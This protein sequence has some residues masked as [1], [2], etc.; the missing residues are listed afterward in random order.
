MGTALIIMVALAGWAL[1]ATGLLLA[2]IGG[3][4]KDVADMRLLADSLCRALADQALEADRHKQQM[5]EMQGQK[6]ELLHKYVEI[7][8][9]YAWFRISMRDLKKKEKKNERAK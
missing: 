3:A 7:Q 2:V 5:R 9:E 8:N 4:S 1:L 6:I